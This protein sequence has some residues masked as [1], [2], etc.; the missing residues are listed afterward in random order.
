MAHL[1]K[2]KKKKGGQEWPFLKKDN[3]FN[4]KEN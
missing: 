2:K 3:T 4:L 1:K